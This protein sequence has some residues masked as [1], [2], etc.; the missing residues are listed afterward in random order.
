MRTSLNFKWSKRVLSCNWSGFRTGS[1]IR[2][3]NHLKYGQMGHLFVENHLKSRQNVHILTVPL[4]EQLELK[5]K[6][7]HLKSFFQKVRIS[8][9][10]I[11]NCLISDHMDLKS[12]HL[13]PEHKQNQDFLKVGFQIPNHVLQG[14]EIQPFQI[15]TYLR[16]RLFEGRMSDP[17]YCFVGI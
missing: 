12:N 14:S 4:F 10:W 1:E 11:L 15:W 3:R 16:S 5:L 8:S 9:F 7:D 13:K 6:Y 17:Y 2:K